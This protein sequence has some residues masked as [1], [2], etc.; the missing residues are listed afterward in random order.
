MPPREM[1]EIGKLAGLDPQLIE[2]IPKILE[3]CGIC[4]MWKKLPPKQVAKKARSVRFG[5]RL[6]ADLFFSTCYCEG[7][8]RD[9]TA[10]HL[11]DDAT[12]LCLLPL[13]AGKTEGAIRGGITRWVEIW[14]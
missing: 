7:V 13:L 9:T 14:G 5:Q 6:W 12:V 4:K 1:Q 10:L 8:P 2:E 11:L 3:D